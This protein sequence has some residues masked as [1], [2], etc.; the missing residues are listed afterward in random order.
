[1]PAPASPQA[2]EGAAPVPAKSVSEE[3]PAKP[4][5]EKKPREKRR[6]GPKLMPPDVYRADA[7]SLATCRGLAG[8][9]V[10][11][12][13]FSLL[14]LGWLAISQPTAG[15]EGAVIVNRT[16][17]AMLAASYFNVETAPDWARLVLLA[18]AMQLFF[19]AWMMA[20]PDWAGVWVVMVVFA[21]VSTAYGM[22]TAMAIAWPVDKPM[23]LGMEEVRRSAGY[24]CGSVLA[25]TALGTYLCGRLSARWRRTCELELAGRGRTRSAR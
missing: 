5:R 8:V 1:M 24:W 16:L 10:L 20:A 2:A 9:L 23:L 4:P 3:P 25:V 22:V 19:I 17:P 7:G 11:V 18:A 6:R 21:L 12:V 15:G 14:P 13:L